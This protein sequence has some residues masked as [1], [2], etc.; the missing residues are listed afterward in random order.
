[1]SRIKEWMEDGIYVSFFVFW[2]GSE[3]LWIKIITFVCGVAPES[4][5]LS[6]I[7]TSGVSEMTE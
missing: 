4:E 2:W 5:S 7:E 6:L 1:M 3:V